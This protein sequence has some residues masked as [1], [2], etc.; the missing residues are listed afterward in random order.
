VFTNW[1]SSAGFCRW[2]LN[3]KCYQLSNIKLIHACINLSFRVLASNLWTFV[4]SR[5]EIE[6]LIL[7]TSISNPW[8]LNFMVLFSA[9]RVSNIFWAILSKMEN[10][11]E[12]M[13]EDLEM[14]VNFSKVKFKHHNDWGWPWHGLEWKWRG[15]IA[16][17]QGF[18][19]ANHRRLGKLSVVTWCKMTCKWCKMTKGWHA[20]TVRWRENY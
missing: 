5:S 12:I 2:T 11:L 6:V 15:P 4:L 9:Q 10:D 3:I 7:V 16:T 14:L 8:L 13:E 20:N 19:L 1:I 18:P 17:P